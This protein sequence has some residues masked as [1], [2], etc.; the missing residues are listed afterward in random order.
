MAVVW[1]VLVGQAI[2]CA[3]LCNDIA[4]KKGYPSS[5]SIWGFLFGIIGLLYV[6]GLPPRAIDEIAPEI[7]K[8]CPDCAESIKAEATVCRFCGRKFEEN[9]IVSKLIDNLKSDKQ[10]VVRNA[11]QALQDYDDPTI[12]PAILIYV[13]KI[14]ISDRL[15]VDE[16]EECLIPLRMAL[17][18]LIKQCTP[19]VASQL[20][21]IALETKSVFK[22]V[23]LIKALAA[24]DQSETIPALLDAI[25]KYETKNIVE[26][27]LIGYG[28]AA[29]PALKQRANNGSKKEKKLA[30]NILSKIYE[31]A[32]MER[33]AKYI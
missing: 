8:V 29:I 1:I 12:I 24:M 5:Y 32:G 23:E 3:Y 9:Q 6:I 20:A 27:A 30:D 15:Y 17:Q 10:I 31:R 33:D 22:H 4:S 19:S 26:K 13:K 14:D 16:R 18:M 7:M 2:I 25:D 11:L 21:T 28:K